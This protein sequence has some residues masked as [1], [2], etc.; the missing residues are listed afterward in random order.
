MHYSCD[1]QGNLVPPGGELC[2]PV[3]A[4]GQSKATGTAGDDLTLTVVGGASYS[5]C[6][7]ATGILAGI[8]GVTST[9]ANIEWAIPL[10]TIAVIKIPEGKTTLY[11]E[12]TVGSKYIYIAKLADRVSS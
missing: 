9:A 5:I 7:I 4:S 12:G 3:A 11:F 2:A 10:D 6:G 1:N 8:T